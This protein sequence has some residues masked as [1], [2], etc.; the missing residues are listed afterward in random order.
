MGANQGQHAYG[1]GGEDCRRPAQLPEAQ[2]LGADQQQRWR[3][4]HI[5]ALPGDKGGGGKGVVWGFRPK[6]S[7]R[8]SEQRLWGAAYVFEIHGWVVC[9]Q[10]I[11][12]G[13]ASA[14][15]YHCG[16]SGAKQP[17]QRPDVAGA[18]AAMAAA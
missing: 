10:G 16:S 4:V 12:L 14:E 8:G 7:V 6:T 2:V 9:C 11:D 13:A 5:G 3:G 17:C 18:A 1:F 15:R